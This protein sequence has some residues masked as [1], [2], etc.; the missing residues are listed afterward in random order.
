MV[1]ALD[2]D[3]G[4]DRVA[5]DVIYRITVPSRSDPVYVHEC[6]RWENGDVV[7]YLLPT[8]HSGARR[9]E[10][11]TQRER[12]EEF[13]SVV[14]H[15]LRNPLS[16]AVGN[17]ELARELDGDAAD[18]RLERVGGALDRMDALISDLLAL[19]RE[20]RTVEETSEAPLR[21]VAESAWRTV[22][23]A[24][25][26]LVVESDL[27]IV[28]CDRG[29]LQQVF[30]NLVRNAIEHAGDDVTLS[31]GT[32]PDGFYVADDGPGVPSEHRDEVFDPGFSTDHDGTGF[33]LAIVE[34]ITKAHGWEVTLAETDGGAR[35]DFTG[36]DRRGR[37]PSVP[38]DR[39]GDDAA[40]ERSA[41][42]GGD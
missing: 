15:D 19:A 35:F 36:V 16:V 22:D 12:L 1:E 10:L 29:R 28:D 9:E 34:R 20:G 37:E 27:G 17:L 30:E 42:D 11:E 39:D 21:S 8:P 13:A 40:P 25:A 33:G 23:D 31:I 6:G 32:L 14:S 4:A 3:T 38:V 41:T 5:V 18:E 2:D 26:D 7:G 24:N